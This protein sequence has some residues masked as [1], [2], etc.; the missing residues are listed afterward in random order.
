MTKRQQHGSGGK[1]RQ[2]HGSGEKAKR[3][4]LPARRPYCDA[5][6]KDGTTCRMRAGWG[7]THPGTGTC[8]FHG[9][10][11]DNRGSRHPA[12]KHGL[13][14][15][16]LAPEDLTEFETWA[17]QYEL[18]QVTRDDL[19]ALYRVHKAVAEAENVPL[20]VLAQSVAALARTK[21][22]LRQAVDGIEVRL[23]VEGA[24][25]DDLV[26]KVAGILMR[27]VPSDRLEAALGDLSDAC[28]GA[29]GPSS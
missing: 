3:Q 16:T 14:A 20:R 26:D 10:C 23:H 19:Y 12:Y 29:V 24:D 1:A 8:R 13:Y 25:L 22:T 4:R 5:H 28:R 6:K 21:A 15:K 11:I 2:Q 27:Y 9:G 18:A 17:A 7:T